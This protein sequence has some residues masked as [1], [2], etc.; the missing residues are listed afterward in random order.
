[1]FPALT[2]SVMARCCVCASPWLRVLAVAV[3][4]LVVDYAR[5]VWLLNGFPW[6]QV[7]YSQLDTPLSGFAPLVGVYGVGFLLVLSAAVL[8][9]V[10]QRQLA[11]VWGVALLLLVWGGGAG[12]RGVQW[13]QPM[14]APITMT[15]VQ[16]NVDQAH[17]WQPNHKLATL[18]LYQQL[19]E[20]H[21]DSQVIVWPE[22]AIPAFRSQVQQF[23]LEPLAEQARQHGV[24]LVVSLPT[25]GVGKAYYNSVLTLG[26]Q[27]ALYHK[28]HLLPFGE[29][30]PLQPLSGWVLELI[31]IP[32]GDFSAGGDHQ[33]LLRAGGYAFITTICYEDV[34]GQ[35]VNR[36][37]ADAAYLVNV[38]N[39]AWFGDSSQP[40][41]HMQM[42]QMRA[43]ESGRYLVRATNTGLSG[44]VGPDGRLRAQ[45][46]LFTTTTLTE[47][48][49]PM[50]GL[51]PY[52]RWGDGPVFV[53]MLVLLLTAFVGSR[54]R[55]LRAS[56]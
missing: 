10:L 6:L 42:A 12:L 47:R 14:G 40:H 53:L 15:L 55:V 25:E 46:P 37:M 33:T 45:A 29:Y 48:I 50:S 18:Q 7:G 41:Q 35:E 39:D 19:T 30:L 44:F 51:T 17:K 4:W 36:Q 27:S 11:P 8:V 2:A 21:W 26:Q 32:L 20:Q 38:T 22:T 23:Y 24:D 52:A 34:F 49:V 5:G 1:L 43:L 54:R 9:E 13:T 56:A 28:N 3:V 16:G 31:N